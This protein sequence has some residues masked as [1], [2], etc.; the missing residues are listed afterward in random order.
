MNKTKAR[1]L[2]KNPTE[3][4]RKLWKYLR[5][6]QLRSYKFRRQQPLGP[7]IVDF[8]CLEKKL[9]VELAGGQHSMQINYDARRTE[10]LEVHGFRVLRFWNNEV[11]EEIKVVEEVIA[12]ELGL[13]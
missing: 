7:Y 8:V 12:K 1:E 3:A 11:L 5:L 2:R 10:W 9:I 4:E 13:I 6:R